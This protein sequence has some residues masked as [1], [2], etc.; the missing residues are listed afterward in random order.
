MAIVMITSHDMAARTGTAPGLATALAASSAGLMIISLPMNPTVSGMPIRLKHA[1][2]IARPRPTCLRPWPA[3]SSNV[4]ADDLP[5][6]A[7]SSC[8][9]PN[10]VT[11]ISPYAVR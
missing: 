7:G 10:A 4:S 1:I 11:F 5:S 2:A 6:R 8:S 3:R 9:T